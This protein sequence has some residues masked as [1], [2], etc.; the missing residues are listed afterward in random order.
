[1][2]EGIG[3][4]SLYHVGC[5]LFFHSVKQKTVLAFILNLVTKNKIQNTKVAKCFKNKK[6]KQQTKLKFS[7]TYG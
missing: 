6:Q 4:Q 3:G 5:I 1:M 7:T 2:E